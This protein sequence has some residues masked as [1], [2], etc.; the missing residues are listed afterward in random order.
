MAAST[1]II[2]LK[3]VIDKKEQRVL[4]AE[5]DKDF[6]D[7]LFSLLVLPVS[8]II[9]LL[10]NRA[11]VGGLAKIYQSA[12]DLNEDYIQLDQNKDAILKP[13][14]SLPIFS[15]Q[16]PL[17]PPNTVSASSTA[18]NVS[19]VIYKCTSCNRKS[20]AVYTSASSTC[21][22]CFRPLTSYVHSKG[23][24]FVKGLV[25]YM[26]M[27]DLVVSPMPTISNIA[28]FGKYNIKDLSAVEEKVVHMGM[29]EEDGVDADD[30]NGAA[31]TVNSARSGRLLRGAA[32]A[33]SAAAAAEEESEEQR[34]KR[35]LWISLSKE[36]IEED[37]FAFTGSRPARRP[38]KKNRIAQKQVD[39]FQQI[40]IEFKLRSEDY[41]AI[42]SMGV[43]IGGIAM[44][45][46]VFFTFGCLLR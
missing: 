13:K 42:R 15:S 38:K 9:Q 22:Y 25:K 23:G 12:S 44:V 40:H 6:V 14:T 5:A 20:N 24:G 29:N 30:R 36:E 17:L 18:S 11:M 1:P 2:T 21:P 4:F 46:M 7:F 3:L 10:D 45:R 34:R 33:G 43:S 26:V 19:A 28:L 41:E 37:V 8:N 39:E 16:L 27:D 35:R 32:G 31:S